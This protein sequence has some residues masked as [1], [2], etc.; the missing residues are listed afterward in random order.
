MDGKATGTEAAPSIHRAARS[1]ALP[2]QSPPV[3]LAPGQRPSRG[4]DSFLILTAAF[5]GDPCAAC[6][7]ARLRMIASASA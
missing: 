3:L 6:Y 4:L 2:L 7:L 5:C 1:P